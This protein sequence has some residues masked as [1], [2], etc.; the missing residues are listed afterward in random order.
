MYYI[1]W[2]EFYVHMVSYYVRVDKEPLIRHD[3]LDEAQDEAIKI[4]TFLNHTVQIFK[5]ELA[6]EVEP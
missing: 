2:G 3:A 4:A 6:Y 5:V 1:K